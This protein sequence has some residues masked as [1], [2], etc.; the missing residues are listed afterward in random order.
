MKTKFYRFNWSVL[1][2]KRIYSW[3]IVLTILAIFHIADVMTSEN[4]KLVFQL[5]ST[6]GSSQIDPIGP[7][8]GLV[9]RYELQVDSTNWFY[10]VLLEN[11]IGMSPLT[12]LVTLLLTSCGI[13]LRGV[14]YIAYRSIS[15][16]IEFN[17]L[18]NYHIVRIDNFWLC[19][20]SAGLFWLANVMKKGYDLQK[21]QNLT[22]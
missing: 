17:Q 22:I 8:L 19:F 20:T 21:E 13:L 5:E 1:I 10:N 4:R 7:N 16:S 14:E 12:T 18:E 11:N 2:M 15:N 6:S 9:H 3:V